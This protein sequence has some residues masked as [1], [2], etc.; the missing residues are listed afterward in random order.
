MLDFPASELLVLGRVQPC[1][2]RDDV[3]SHL[4]V[5]KQWAMGSSFLK[6]VSNVTISKE[7]ASPFRNLAN[8]TSN[9]LK[10]CSCCFLGS[11]DRI[12]V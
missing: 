9:E 3:G 10:F 1:S 5:E 7:I 2:G 6:D 8:Q 4:R 11:R 12:A